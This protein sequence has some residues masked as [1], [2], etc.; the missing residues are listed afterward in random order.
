MT[1]TTPRSCFRCGTPWSGYGNTCNACKTID[2]INDPS[3]MVTAGS[4]SANGDMP[5]PMA[6]VIIGIFLLIDYNLNFFICKIMWLLLK[7]GF[8]LMFGWWMG[9]EVF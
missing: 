8:Y 7:V 5:L 4:A 9:I 1:Y 6:L 3:P 2:A